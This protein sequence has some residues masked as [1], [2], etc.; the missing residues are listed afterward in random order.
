MRFDVF[1]FQE[2]GSLPGP[3]AR[4]RSTVLQVL[5]SGARTFFLEE[6]DNRD[7]GTPSAEL[8]VEKA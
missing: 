8:V 2:F 7:N 6:I 1:L 3:D 4:L 5:K